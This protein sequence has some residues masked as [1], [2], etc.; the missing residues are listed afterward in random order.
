[1]AD[2]T[3]GS[4]IERGLVAL[5]LLGIV[6][7]FAI[8][9]MTGGQ[10]LNEARIAPKEPWLKLDTS[11]LIER[12]AFASCADQKKPQPIWAG[13]LDT[14]PNLL[15]MMGDN[16]YGDIKDAS[17][18]EL[19]AA[20][21]AFASHPDFAK[22]RAA[23]PILATWDDHDYG[24]NDAGGNFPL[25]A[26]TRRL[27]DE[28]WAVGP[29]RRSREGVYDAQIFG[30]AG[31][32]VQVI[33]LD[34]RSFRSPWT[35]KQAG[36]NWRGPYGP[37][38]N[39]KLTILGEEQWSWLEKELRK[40]AEIRFI[41]SSIQV[42]AEH[43]GFERWGNFPAERQR[44]YDLVKRTEARGVV[45]LTGDRHVGAIYRKS[46]VLPYPVIDITSSSINRPLLPQYSVEEGGSERQGEA[47]RDENFGLASIDWAA[48]KLTLALYGLKGKDPV[49]QMT[50]NFADLG[51]D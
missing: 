20:Y 40:P 29:E 31:K 26:T 30:P 3:S 45:L 24:Q 41:V 25:K 7:V 36:A 39:P 13:L 50:V 47:Y 32:R 15:L 44:L 18:K 17:A 42:V 5:L 46:G 8:F 48:R 51:L 6:G 12:M 33:L 22:V 34:T 16:V 23:M 38:A 19:K 9:A 35:A 1:M 28:F 14:R 2:K 10:T 21:S 4:L 11:T 27:F 49:R 37:D 43:H